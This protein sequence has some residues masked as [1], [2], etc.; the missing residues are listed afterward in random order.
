MAKMKLDIKALDKEMTAFNCII[1][2]QKRLLKR[3]WETKRRKFAIIEND[4]Q[5]G[6]LEKWKQFVSSIVT[7]IGQPI[8]IE[9]S[10]LDCLK[11]TCIERIHIATVYDMLAIIVVTSLVTIQ[12]V[13]RN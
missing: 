3:G 5:N 6:S 10:T 12:M 9:L 8:V 11:V 13:M 1:S 4:G 2:M 7:N